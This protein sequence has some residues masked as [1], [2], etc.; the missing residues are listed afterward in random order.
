MIERPT[1]HAL[2]RFLATV[3]HGAMTAAAE[4]EGISQPVISARIRALE[5]FY[6]WDSAT[7]ERSPRPAHADQEW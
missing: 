3:E 7:P 2:A 4:A 5:R 1:L 6:R